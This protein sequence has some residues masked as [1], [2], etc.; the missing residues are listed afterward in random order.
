MRYSTSG[1]QNLE[2]S[3]ILHFVHQLLFTNRNRP[4]RLVLM[5]EAVLSCRWPENPAS[6]MLSMSSFSHDSMKYKILQFFYVPM[7]RY[8]WSEL[9]HFLSNDCKLANRTD[10]SLLFLCLFFTQMTGIWVCSRESNIYF[11]SESIKK[12]SLSSL[13]WVIAVLISI[14]YFWS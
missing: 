2:T 6:C 10:G 3:L 1:K 5:E 8:P 13:R 12:K 14:S 9:I 4:P 11:A 7:V